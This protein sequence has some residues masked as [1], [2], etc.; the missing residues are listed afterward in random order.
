[1]DSAR[2][3]RDFFRRFGAAGMERHVPPKYNPA[4]LDFIRPMLSPGDRILDVGCGYG[5]V[6][7]ALAKEGWE[8]VGVDIAPNLIDE[9]RARAAKR[10]VAVSFEVGDM[11]RLAFGDAEFDK[12]LCL[13]S[14]LNHLL[15]REEQLAALNEMMRV[16]KPGGLL[17]A[18]VADGGRKDLQET[19]KTQGTGPDRRVWLK[20]LDGIPLPEYLYDLK[21]LQAL[22]AEVPASERNVEYVTLAGKR[23]LVLRMT[24]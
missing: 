5:R 9:A 10:G 2:V 6:A 13:W 18:E 14:G 16:L 3:V 24:R 12:A 11:R 8:V 7:L 1:M 23:R 20:K 4:T 15:T 21:T 17:I 19:L 22:A